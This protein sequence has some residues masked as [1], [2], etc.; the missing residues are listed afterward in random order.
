MN[1]TKP[2]VQTR[3][4]VLVFVQKYLLGLRKIKTLKNDSKEEKIQRSLKT[5]KLLGSVLGSRINIL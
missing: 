4:Q 5:S 3:T 2:S 1:L